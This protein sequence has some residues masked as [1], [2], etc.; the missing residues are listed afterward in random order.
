VGQVVAVL[1]GQLKFKDRYPSL[2][3]FDVVENT[4]IYF[5]GENYGER[6]LIKLNR[7]GTDY[8]RS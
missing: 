2:I 4:E 7:R 6:N 5:I 8:D 3:A 1:H